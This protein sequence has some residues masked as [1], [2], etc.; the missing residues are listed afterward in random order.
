MDIAAAKKRCEAATPGDWWNESGV[1]HVAIGDGR[2]S[3]PASVPLRVDMTEE[4]LQ[5]AEDDAKFIAH[6]RTDLPAALEALEEAQAE[7]ASWHQEFTVSLDDDSQTQY[8]MDALEVGK[9]V[10]DAEAGARMARQDLKEAQVLLPRL[11]RYLYPEAYGGKVLGADRLELAEAV[12]RIL[13]GSKGD[14]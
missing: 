2:A 7:L 8:R 9:M 14:E 3:H 13:R 10:Q 11:K 4:E 5:Q 12:D 1:I 6:A